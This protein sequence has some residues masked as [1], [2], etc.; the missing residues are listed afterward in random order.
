MSKS[1]TTTSKPRFATP[2]V[3]A[4]IAD[5]WAEEFA[6]LLKTTPEGIRNDGV[7]LLSLELETVRVELMDG[8]AVEFRY[9]CS[10]VSGE[11]RAIAV[12]TEH[13]GHHIFPIHEAK[14]YHG[15]KLIYQQIGAEYP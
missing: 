14:L 12:L 6:V 7:D 8:S 11:K 5:Q 9:A 3:A 4:F 10:V 13:C 2:A 1:Q 15:E